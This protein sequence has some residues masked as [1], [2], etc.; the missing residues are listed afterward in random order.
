[1]SQQGISVNQTVRNKPVPQLN[2]SQKQLLKGQRKAVA[3]NT[4]HSLE[5]AADEEGELVQSSVVPWPL[6]PST[7]NIQSDTKHTKTYTDMS[8]TK[9]DSEIN[10]VTQSHTSLEMKVKEDVNNS[11]TFS[12]NKSDS[13][14]QKSDSAQMNNLC[15]SHSKDQQLQEEEKFLLAKIRLMS[16][17]S[18]PVSSIH[19]MKR[20]IPAP[21]DIDCDTEQPKKQLDIATDLTVVNQHL[22]FPSFDTLQE[23][24]LTETEEPQAEENA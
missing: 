15:T 16:G 14:S 12:L 11:K 23:I 13:D 18:S 19:N 2:E 8:V 7:S 3:T 24:S 20:L 1:M 5:V 21:G 22:V 9:V 4:S 10:T 17:D 6:P